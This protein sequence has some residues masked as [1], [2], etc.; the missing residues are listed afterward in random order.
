MSCYCGSG[1]SL[2]HCCL[3]IIERKRNAETAEQLLRARYSAFVLQKFSFL[4][5][6]TAPEAAQEKD[7]IENEKWAKKVE[8]IELKII[9]SSEQNLQGQV[10]FKVY[11]NDSKTVYCHH[12]ISQFRKIESHWY[13]R[14]SASVK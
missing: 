6:T 9:R 10:Q 13:Y 1:H 7:L 8:F 2:Y 3:P 4:R 5:D 14:G 11:F 12:E